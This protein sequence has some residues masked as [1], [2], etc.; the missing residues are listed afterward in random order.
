VT[1]IILY[2]VWWHLFLAALHT[3][4][5]MK[6]IARVFQDLLRNNLLAYLH[7]RTAEHD[8]E[9]LLFL[10]EFRNASSRQPAGAIFYTNL[11]TLDPYTP[12]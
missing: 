11:P 7:T 2:F 8:N 12:V 6:L 3:F 9:L 4:R 10:S 5:T 1:V